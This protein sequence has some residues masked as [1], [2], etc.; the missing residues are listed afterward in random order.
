MG[1]LFEYTIIYSKTPESIYN[2]HKAKKKTLTVRN[3]I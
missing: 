2:K 1:G 3:N